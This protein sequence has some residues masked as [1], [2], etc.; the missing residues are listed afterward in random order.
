MHLDKNVT[1]VQ[2]TQSLLLEDSPF[3]SHPAQSPSFVTAPGDQVP[4]RCWGNAAERE[5]VILTY[6]TTRFVIARQPLHVFTLQ[7]DNLLESFWLE[8]DCSVY[9]SMC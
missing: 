7:A 4:Q 6:V 5:D 2:I 9:L 3:I 8:A 1:V